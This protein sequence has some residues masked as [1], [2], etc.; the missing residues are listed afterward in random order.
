MDMICCTNNI[1]SNWHGMS[2]L[3][4]YSTSPHMASATIY[5]LLA[6]TAQ[7]SAPHSQ[8]HHYLSP[9]RSTRGAVLDVGG[10]HKV[11][12]HTWPV[13]TGLIYMC[14]VV[15]CCVGFFYFLEI[16]LAHTQHSYKI[17]RRDA[18]QCKHIYLIYTLFCVRLLVRA[19]MVSWGHLKRDNVF[20]VQ[21][22]S[23]LSSH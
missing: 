11:N 3:W 10:G 2:P 15:L 6:T 13:A 1:F 7:L 18:M 16:M 4:R 19:D 9:L 5:S 14:L 8:T 20:C 17:F 22:P 21:T 23:F 12:T